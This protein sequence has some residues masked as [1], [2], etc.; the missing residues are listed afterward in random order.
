MKVS[1][2]GSE[3]SLDDGLTLRDALDEAGVQVPEGATIGIV[4]GR[5]E[6]EKKTDSYWLNTTKGKL[7]IELLGTG[8]Q[9]VWHE[10]VSQIPGLQARWSDG[11]AVAFGPITTRMA[12]SRGGGGVRPVGGGPGRQRL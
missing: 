6:V 11:A 10:A 3:I 5:E 8:L 9:D 2:N 7:R 1:V 4:K 12:P